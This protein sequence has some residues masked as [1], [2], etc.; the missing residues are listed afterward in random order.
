MP[1]KNTECLAGAGNLRYKWDIPL[2]QTQHTGHEALLR[3]G[4]IEAQKHSAKNSG[5]AALP[6][7]LFPEVGMPARS[8]ADDGAR[9]VH[10]YIAAIAAT[11]LSTLLIAWLQNAIRGA[12]G[13]VYR[14]YT[15]L[16]VCAIAPI[17][18]LYGIRP[19]FV[20]YAA[21]LIA[22]FF[23]L[24]PGFGG[25]AA[26]AMLLRDGVEMAAMAVAGALVMW[27]A[28]SYRRQRRH[29]QSAIAHLEAV[30][31]ARERVLADVL[32]SATQ[33][34]LQ[35]Y[36]RDDAMPS[37]LSGQATIT[38]TKP[39]DLSVLRAAIREARSKRVPEDDRCFRFLSAAHETALNAILHGSGGIAMIGFTDEAR[40]TLA[41]QITDNGPRIDLEQHP[42]RTLETGASGADSLGMGFSLV[43]DG[44]DRI[45]LRTNT[46]GTRILLEL[47]PEPPAPTWFKRLLGE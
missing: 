14:P 25:T 42:E 18:F 22:T 26:R 16:Y 28:Y 33:G 37:L 41:V 12:G 27:G 47:D 46:R 36:N 2:L 21:A 8:G 45:H 19:G 43:L 31:A 35:L 4:D 10:G 3:I 13:D 11:V 6:E 15:I 30:H 39:Q 9:P 40:E 34:K 1:V 29:L 5:S 23:W 44:A 20:V 32:R 17:V 7:P 38:L 24:A